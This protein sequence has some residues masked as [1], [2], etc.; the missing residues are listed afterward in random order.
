[1]S[2]FWPIFFLLVVLKIP[3]L[4]P[5]VT[6][7]VEAVVDPGQR[8]A[9][10]VL[11]QGPQLPVCRAEAGGA[12]E[13]Q[14]RELGEP[15]DVRQVVVGF[16][17]PAGRPD[18]LEMLCEPKQPLAGAERDAVHHPVDELEARG[19]A[20]RRLVE[21]EEADHPVDVD[22]EQR[23]GHGREVAYQR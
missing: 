18:H 22:G 20:G 6:A 19:R 10:A 17:L 1:V 2:G 3:V 14:V 21:A 13:G 16:L 5:L 9:A 11:V 23:A 15:E 12:A 4:R 7:L 8:P